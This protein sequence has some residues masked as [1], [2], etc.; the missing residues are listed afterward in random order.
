MIDSLAESGRSFTYTGYDVSAEMVEEARGA[1]R[2]RRERGSRA[3]PAELEQADF[4]VAS[5]VFNVK[6][7]AHDDAWSAYVLETIAE[8][9]RLSSPR[10]RLQRADRARRPGASPRRSLL[11]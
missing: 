10:L 7:D 8:L 2:T 1:T 11:R 4:T 3:T 9:A 6:Q 5:G